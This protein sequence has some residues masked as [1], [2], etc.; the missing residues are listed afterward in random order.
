MRRPGAREGSFDS[1]PSA[2]RNREFIEVGVH[3]GDSGIVDMPGQL[4]LR[5]LALFVEGTVGPGQV[6]APGEGDTLAPG[7][8]NVVDAQLLEAVRIGTRPHRRHPLARCQH[9]SAGHPESA[10]LRH[11]RFQPARLPYL[12]LAREKKQHLRLRVA[13]GGHREGLTEELA[14]TVLHSETGLVGVGD[15]ATGQHIHAPTE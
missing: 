4:C 5:R 3:A 15:H 14:G 10:Q 8:K 2:L 9:A 1:A 13:Q 12:H 11:Q 6:A 7:Q